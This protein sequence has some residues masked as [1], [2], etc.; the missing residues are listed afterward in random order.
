MT[1][2]NIEKQFFDAVDNGDCATV[3]SLLSHN[4]ISN[5]IWE[6]S[7]HNS[8][9]KDDTAMVYALV[10]NIDINEM[11]QDTAMLCV[12][13][14]IDA[15]VDQIVQHPWLD[16]N[17]RQQFAFVISIDKIFGAHDMIDETKSCY[18]QECLMY[19][20]QRVC[21]LQKRAL[22]RSVEN[23]RVEHNNTAQRKRL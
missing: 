1:P 3:R 13:H 20:D 15:I 2:L 6:K 17:V 21:A 22:E 12:G 16:C 9:E 7:L 10:E 5:D 11:T 14:R 8:S 4:K 19:M 18:A 23:S